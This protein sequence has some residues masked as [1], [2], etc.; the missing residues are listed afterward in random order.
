MPISAVFTTYAPLRLPE[1]L[2]SKLV[3][4]VVIEEDMTGKEPEVLEKLT[5]LV[6]ELNGIK[7]KLDDEFDQ[8]VEKYKDDRAKLAEKLGIKENFLISDLSVLKKQ[9]YSGFK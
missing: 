1:E 3:T 5:A 9:Y 7:V 4:K 6:L 2:A 8:T